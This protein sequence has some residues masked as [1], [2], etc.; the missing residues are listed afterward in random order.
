MKYKVQVDSVFEYTYLSG[1]KA[2]CSIDDD[3]PG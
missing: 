1:F 2:L 3:G